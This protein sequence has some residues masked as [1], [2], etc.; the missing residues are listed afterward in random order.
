[1]FTALHTYNTIRVTRMLTVAICALK[2]E[3]KAPP[4]AFHI[5]HL[6]FQWREVFERKTD[7][8]EE[9]SNTEGVLSY[10]KTHS[11]F[12]CV[13]GRA[14]HKLS[15]AISTWFIA[16][17][18]SCWHLSMFTHTAVSQNKGRGVRQ[19]G[20]TC[21]TWRLFMQQSVGMQSY[22]TSTV[23]DPENRNCSSFCI[24]ANLK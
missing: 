24:C 2:I 22:K 20:S 9:T 23:P 14:E 1:M 4:T 17:N 18:V 16:K 21:V 11:M 8:N 3:D 19:C 6:A 12:A 13:F 10:I 15:P 7:K 5:T